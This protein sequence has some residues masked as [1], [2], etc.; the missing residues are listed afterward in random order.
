MKDLYN[1]EERFEQAKDKL[2]QTMQVSSE[3]KGLIFKFI[4][5]KQ[6]QGAGLARCTATCKNKAC[7]LATGEWAW[8]QD[9]G[10]S[11]SSDDTL[12]R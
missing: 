12:P 1:F 6:A 3:N 10:V 5:Y 2:N 4:E 8:G 11:H 7:V 9:L